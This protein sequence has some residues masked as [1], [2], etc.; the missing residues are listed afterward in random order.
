M[1]YLVKRVNYKKG[2]GYKLQYESRK[3]GGRVATDLPKDKWLSYGF[4]PSMTFAEAKAQ[5]K[6]L[7][8]REKL[9]RSAEKRLATESRIKDLELVHSAY[10]ALPDILDFEKRYLRAGIPES[11][12]LTHKVN[13]YWAAAKGIICEL[14]LDIEEW[15]DL[16][17][18][19][20]AA[21]KDRQWSP[22]YVRKVLSI[23]NLWGAYQARKYRRMFLQIPAPRRQDM[24]RIADAYF[25]KYE[26]GLVS[27]PLLPHQ[28]EKARSSLP[29][30]QYNWLYLTVWLGLRPEEADNAKDPAR[31][32]IEE[33][34][35]K[36]YQSKLTTIAR[37][38]R[39]KHIQ[40]LEKEQAYCLEI[41][42]NHPIKRPLNKTIKK[43]CGDGIT[44]YAGRKG[45][46][47]LMLDRGH[48]LEEISMWMGHHTI[49]RTWKYYKN[50]QR[51]K[52]VA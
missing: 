46:T 33:G 45:F 12:R 21:F 7:N 15:S 14:K 9:E 22:S 26:N 23:L 27:K 5:V 8:A 50:R 6:T 40:L 20:Y 30:T 52:K 13:S 19:F 11:E 28:L 39:W 43:Y 49:D 29:E 4:S 18:S 31:C 34:L 25:D 32:I 37:P 38:L 36:V 17:R 44:G 2:P 35:V 24:Q 16:K 41:I 42:E 47:D 10:L 48:G 1:G 3:N 51:F